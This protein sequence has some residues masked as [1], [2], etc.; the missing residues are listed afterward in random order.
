MKNNFKRTAKGIVKKTV[1]EMKKQPEKT[2][3]IGGVTAACAGYGAA[4]ILSNTFW[5]I[6]YSLR[7]SVQPPAP[8]PPE[9]D[10]A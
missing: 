4:K 2:V 7:K 3:V 1:K 8:V 9:P 10:Q 5:R 6:K